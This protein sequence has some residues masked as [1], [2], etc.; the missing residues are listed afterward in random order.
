MDDRDFILNKFVILSQF[1]I[2]EDHLLTTRMIILKNCVMK[3]I[4]YLYCRTMKSLTMSIIGHILTLI[5]II[6][7]QI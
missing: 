7:Y 4:F 2:F 5:H 1:M 6:F 3:N